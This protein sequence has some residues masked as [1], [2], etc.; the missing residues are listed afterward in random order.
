MWRLTYLKA[1]VYTGTAQK[2]KNIHTFRKR[3]SN[4]QSHGTVILA[5]LQDVNSNYIFFCFEINS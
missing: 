1:S 3:D 4:Q 2:R 5:N